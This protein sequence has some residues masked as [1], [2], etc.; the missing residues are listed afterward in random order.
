MDAI[1]A[2]GLASNVLHIVG[3]AAKLI[4]IANELGNDTASSENRDYQVIT[5]HLEVLAKNISDSTR[6]IS[7]AYTAASPEEQ[8][9]QPVADKCCELAKDLLNRLQKCGIKPNQNGS[10]LQRTKAS[11]KA[12]WNKREIRDISDRLQFFRSEL[13]IHYTT[14]IRQTQ[15]D[16]QAQQV[17]TADIQ[18]AIQELRRLEPLIDSLKIDINEGINK[19]QDEILNSFTILRTDNSQLYTQA[20]QQAT[21]NQKVVLDKLSNIR[22]SVETV[23]ISLQKN[24]TLRA[25]TNQHTL[26][27]S[28][29]SASYQ[30]ALRPLLKEYSDR[31]LREIKKEFRRTA[32]VELDNLESPLHMLGGMQYRGGA[33]HMTPRSIGKDKGERDGG[34]LEW[35]GLFSSSQSA[36]RSDRRAARQ[37][38][39]NGLTI[40]YRYW[41]DKHTSLG[42]LSLVILSTVHFDAFGHPKRVYELTVQFNPS[43]RWFSTGISVTYQ[44]ISDARGSPVFGHSLKTY[45]VV[46]ASHEVWGAI[47]DGDVQSVQRM[48][49]QRLISTSDRDIYG[50]TFLHRAAFHGA[51]DICKALVHG[52]VDI[53]AHDS[54]GRS[55]IE[56]AFLPHCLRHNAQGQDIFHYLLGLPGIEI[57]GFW[58]NKYQVLQSVT[59]LSYMASSVGLCDEDLQNWLSVCR[60]V[61]FDFNWDVSHGTFMGDIAR[62]FSY[63]AKPHTVDR[64]V[65]AFDKL[66]HRRIGSARSDDGMDIPTAY[67]CC[68]LLNHL[69]ENHERSLIADAASATLSACYRGYYMHP[70]VAS[71]LAFAEYVIS[72]GITENPDSIFDISLGRT[73]SSRFYDTPW[74]RIWE[75]ILEEHGFD[76]EW[77]YEEDDRRKFVVTG[78]T[79]APEVDIEVDASEAVEMKRRRG[80]R[81]A[82]D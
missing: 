26:L 25:M 51:R 53:N 18:T 20:S 40:L 47:Y 3:C 48:L 4:S 64:L 19:K 50:C 49:S 60:L 81:N 39:K 73:T 13:N 21:A 52:G 1:V 63:S 8:A 33:T 23:S 5:L 61:D 65:S 17:P 45:R 15:L 16:Q 7:Q 82:D 6:A 10:R 43:S 58:M 72:K 11:L 75:E 38:G 46:D 42:I 2:V 32:R 31:L 76:V 36:A 74:Q 70:N 55:A 66:V 57:E 22:S 9:L 67:A 34:D 14:Q 28:D 80:Y 56:Y 30:D 12:I 68:C 79:S 71:G 54:Y 37:I 44:K 62:S 24:D 78:E 27:D 35:E 29:A 77:V 59:S 41:W 69:E